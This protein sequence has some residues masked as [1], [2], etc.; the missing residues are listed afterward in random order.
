M[1]I[2]EVQG[3]LGLSHARVL[4]F[5]RSGRLPAR[6]VGVQWMIEKKDLAKLRIKKVGRPPGKKR[7]SR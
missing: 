5:I 4:Q 3:K 6:K 7:G 2:A 1:T